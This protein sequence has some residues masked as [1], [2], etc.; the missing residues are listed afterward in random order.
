MNEGHGAAS[1]NTVRR[2]ER[3]EGVASGSLWSYR[4]NGELPLCGGAAWAMGPDL[5]GHWLLVRV[6]EE[7]EKTTPGPALADGLPNAFWVKAHN[8]LFTLCSWPLG[9]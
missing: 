5:S 4:H 3:Q 9:P 2:K 6:M 8:C 1:A 7:W